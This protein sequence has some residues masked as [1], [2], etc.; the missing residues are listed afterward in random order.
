MTGPYEE[1]Q[2]RLTNHK[3]K[4][5]RILI[6]WNA[7][8]GGPRMDVRLVGDNDHTL[9]E[10]N[11]W[12]ILGTREDPGAGLCSIDYI[13][14]SVLGAGAIQNCEAGSFYRRYEIR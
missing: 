2:N 13:V 8:D 1:L 9:D 6:N 4:V 7:S 5:R 3:G 12:M 11:D 14:T 10:W